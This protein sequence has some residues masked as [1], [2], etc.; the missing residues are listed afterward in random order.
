MRADKISTF[1][2][3]GLILSDP[4]PVNLTVAV[5]LNMEMSLKLRNFFNSRAAKKCLIIIPSIALV[6]NVRLKYKPLRLF[7]YVDSAFS[8]T[9]FTYRLSVA[10]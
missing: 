4:K 1:L 9:S 8:P 5:F 7:L 6:I 10:G 2:S 3:K